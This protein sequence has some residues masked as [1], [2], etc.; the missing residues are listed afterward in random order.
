[1][2]DGYDSDEGSTGMSEEKV[3]RLRRI[4]NVKRVAPIETSTPA[5]PWAYRPMIGSE[6]IRRG[7]Y[8]DSDRCREAMLALD[9][10]LLDY[11][12]PS[13]ELPKIVEV[14]QGAVVDILPAD[15]VVESP[16]G[17]RVC[18][19]PV[20]IC[21]K[22]NTGRVLEP[23]EF[24]KLISVVK[25]H[26]ERFVES[27]VFDCF[28]APWDCFLNSLMTS[29]VLREVIKRGLATDAFYIVNGLRARLNMEVATVLTKSNVFK[30]TFMR[31]F[32]NAPSMDKIMR[33]IRKGK[34]DSVAQ[35]DKFLGRVKSL[36]ELIDSVLLNAEHYSVFLPTYITAAQRQLPLRGDNL[37]GYQ[38]D[39]LRPMPGGWKRAIENYSSS[40]TSSKGYSPSTVG[41]RMVESR[42]H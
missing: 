31:I 27:K 9:K 40:V 30:Y 4:E 7:G 14:E 18:T 8:I 21:E 23:A 16:G 11:K 41:G 6:G 19:L 28:S 32:D 25:T 13:P 34:F 33:A 39:D 24:V 29:R 3:N 35:T 26:E 15:G 42:G 1:M 10:A 2:Y 37:L 17:S 5:I 36:K 20:A 38:G 12:I 22:L